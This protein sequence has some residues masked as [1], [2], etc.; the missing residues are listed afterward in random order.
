MSK[1]WEITLEKRFL[2][3]CIC[4]SVLSWYKCR[5]ILYWYRIEYISS[6]LFQFCFCESTKKQILDRTDG[7]VRFPTFSK[8]Y[9]FCFNDC[10]Q[11][12]KYFLKFSL[13][14]RT[15]YSTFTASI[16]TISALSHVRKYQLLKI[17]IKLCILCH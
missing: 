10:R 1:Y 17:A 14:W 2:Q 3:Q 5:A 9:S 7:T 13:I 16:S 4:K 11:V 15:I 12:S 8:L 6:W